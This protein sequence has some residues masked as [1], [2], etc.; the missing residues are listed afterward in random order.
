MKKTLSA[1]LLGTMLVTS[2]TACGEKTEGTAAT[3]TPAATPTAEATATPAASTEKTELKDGTFEGTGKG[4]QGDI[5]VSVTVE[6][7]KISK[8]D[9]LEQKETEAIFATAKDAIPAAII[10]KQSTEVDAVA[11]ATMSSNGI[12]EAVANALAA[13]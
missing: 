8:I 13:K 2:L 10:E 5:K 12:M 6:G 7:G 11:N 9:I 1:L 3:A 4:L